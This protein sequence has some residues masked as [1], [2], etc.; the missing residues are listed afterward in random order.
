MSGGHGGVEIHNAISGVARNDAAAV[1]VVVK[2]IPRGLVHGAIASIGIAAS[3]SRGQS[4]GARF[5][6]L[7][8][9]FE[10]RAF[11]GH[12]GVFPLFAVKSL[13]F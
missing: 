7:I 4:S 1:Q 2:R 5:E 13:A 8:A 6:L 12:V 11:P 9:G 3:V 10:P